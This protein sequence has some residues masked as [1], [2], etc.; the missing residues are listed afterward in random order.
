MLDSLFNHLT[1]F[2]LKG[3]LY[4]SVLAGAAILPTSERAR[5]VF[6]QAVKVA[7][8]GVEEVLRISDSAEV[9]QVDGNEF[10]QVIKEPGRI[11][12]VDFHNEDVALTDR[13]KKKLD[14]AIKHLPSKVL[15]AKVL[16]GR[17]IELMD[18]IQIH[19]IPT[20]R[21]Y[22]DGKLLEEFKGEV[23]SEAFTKVV[24]Y[25]LNNPSSKPHH[26]GYVGPLEKGWLPDGVEVEAK[27]G[28]MTPLNVD[29]QQR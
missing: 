15:V 19:N 22:R 26:T 5:N 20:L 11:V 14:N 29:Y 13:K 28:G 4:I 1:N 18:R 10:D 3:L 27:K 21:V 9:R 12:I 7:A 24:E 17:N 25:H 8:D 2:P 23:E 16:A 6:F